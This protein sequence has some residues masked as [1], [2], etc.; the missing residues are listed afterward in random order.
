MFTLRKATDRGHTNLGWLD[1]HHTFSFGGY[2]DPKHTNFGPLRVIN[3]DVVTPSGGFGEHPH[4]DMEIMTWVLSGVLKHGDSLGNLKS[5]KPG[6]LQVMTAGSGIRHSELNGSDTDP[7]HLLQVW[8]IPRAQG[9][10]PRYD[11]R[12]LSA[13]GRDHQ[14]QLLA[15][16]DSET[17]R[18]EE[19]TMPLAQSARFLVADLKPGRPL[20][21]QFESGRSGWLHLATGKASAAGHDLSAGDA[22]AIT[23]E[24]SI[25]LTASE[26]AQAILFDLA[27]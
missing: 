12:T 24:D 27:D 8:I 25:E 17:D 16:D 6:E 2:Q 15:A 5:L 20:A 23:G 19:N 18:F 4:R 9:V 14:W 1:S 22:L 26:P 13:E 11:Q 10:M 7:V 3:D 21:Y